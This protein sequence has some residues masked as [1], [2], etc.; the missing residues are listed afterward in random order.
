M[1]IRHKNNLRHLESHDLK[2]KPCVYNLEHSPRSITVILQIDFKL[3]Y[4]YIVKALN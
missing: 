1:Q 3:I 2:K 4:K